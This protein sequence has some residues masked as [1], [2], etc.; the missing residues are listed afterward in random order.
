MHYHIVSKGVR[1][2]SFVSLSDRDLCL[3]FLQE[4]YE[5]VEFLPV[6]D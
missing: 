3:G 2:A 4:E 5:D 6:N 1:I